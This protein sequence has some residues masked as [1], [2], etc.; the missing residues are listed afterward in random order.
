MNGEDHI[1]ADKKFLG[2]STE[3]VH[4]LLDSKG[5]IRLLGSG[6]R[7]VRHGVNALEVVEDIAKIRGDNPKKARKVALFHIL[8]DARI[9]DRDWIEKNI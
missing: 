6:H 4:R 9:L 2:Y 5:A 8:I 3:W 1:K 7:V